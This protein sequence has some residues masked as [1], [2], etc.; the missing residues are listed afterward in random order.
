MQ[1]WVIRMVNRIRDVQPVI[2]GGFRDRESDESMLICRCR[3]QDEVVPCDPSMLPAFPRSRARLRGASLAVQASRRKTTD[4]GESSPRSVRFQWNTHAHRLFPELNISEHRV[5][6]F[7]S[8]F[9]TLYF[10]VELELSM[11]N[12]R[13]KHPLYILKRW[14]EKKR[15]GKKRKNY[16]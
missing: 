2:Q 9:E 1:L 11:E 7:S 10:V 16:P 8:I 12:L 13:R 6:A 14:G 4:S 5:Q 15:K 3:G